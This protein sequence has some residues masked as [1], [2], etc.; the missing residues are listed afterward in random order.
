MPHPPRSL[1][2]PRKIAAKSALSHVETLSCGCAANDHPGSQKC[3]DSN[4]P[5]NYPH[6]VIP[7]RDRRVLQKNALPPGQQ[8]PWAVVHTPGWSVK[9]LP[10]S[11][12][13]DPFDSLPIKMPFRSRELY[14]YFYQTGAAFSVA[15]ADANDD[16]I[17]LATL[18]EHALRSTILIAGIHYSWNTGTLQA[19]ESSFLFHKIESIRIINT[20]LQASDRR[21]FVVCVRQILT[22]C[23]AEACLGN[24][25][26]A[27]THLN[28]VMALFG[29]REDADGVCDSSDDIEGELADRYLILTSCF[30]LIL[31]SRL[32]DF[33]LFLAT[34]GIDPSQDA[35]SAEALKLMKTW[36][37]LEHGGLDTR[38]KAMR[39]FPYFFAPPP[40]DR[41]PRMIDASPVLDCLRTITT[42]VDWA[43]M[44]PS[45]AQ[46]HH[47]WNDGGPTKLLLD[48]VNSHVASYAR[49]GTHTASRS[50]PAGT[51]AADPPS[52][53]RTPVYS[54]WSGLSAAGELYIHSVLG[55]M[56]AG[57][58][59]ECRLLHRVALILQRDV[60]QTRADLGGDGVVQSLWFW[61]VFLGGLALHRHVS[62]DVETVVRGCAG[63]LEGL[64]RWFRGC[65]KGWSAVTGLSH[66]GDVQCV[67][68]RVTWPGVL[69]AGEVDYAAHAWAQIAS[70][71]L[72]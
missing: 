42:T 24:I 9:R 5:C 1:A 36:H 4:K 31:K 32:E 3:L 13:M 68:A 72:E 29:S 61:K 46:L 56:N 71:G 57:S 45:P 58:P 30:V 34:Q 65:A 12:A 48:L 21:A 60:Q 26:A 54:S 7:L 28:G 66:W 25:P 16:C 63:E 6:A 2:K 39:L 51:T 10:A 69:P 43:R 62:V 23:L 18:D 49:D 22:M 20:W 38:L 17:A 47:V 59:L 40:T 15:P 14:H 67:L 50:S 53:S 19:Y 37:G 64:Y 55:I 11:A 35:S 70:G 41:R 52:E 33:K 44:D 27:E 8:A